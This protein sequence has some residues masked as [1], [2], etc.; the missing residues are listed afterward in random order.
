MELLEILSNLS[1]AGLGLL[2][3]VLVIYW[4]RIDAKEQV[5]EAEK[6][7]VE[8]KEQSQQEREDKLLLIDSLQKNT[9]VLAE[10]KVLVERFNGKS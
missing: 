4:N 2:I 7:V 10:L 8:A 9:R 3:A 1:D 5:A 6:R